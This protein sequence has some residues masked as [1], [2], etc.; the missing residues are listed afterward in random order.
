MTDV[1][2]LVFGCAVSFVACAGAYVYLRTCLERSRGSAALA[3]IPDAG[4]GEER[5]A[6][7]DP[8]GGHRAR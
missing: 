6:I 1:D 2:L 7:G 5:H 4:R 8:A 3:A